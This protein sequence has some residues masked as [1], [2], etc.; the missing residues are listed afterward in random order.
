M[1]G[2]GGERDGQNGNLHL[3]TLPLLPCKSSSPCQSSHYLSTASGSIATIPVLFSCKVL[4]QHLL[5]LTNIPAKLQNSFG[6]RGFSLLWRVCEELKTRQQPLQ[7]QQQQQQ[8][9]QK[10]TMVEKNSEL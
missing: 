1:S 4:H 5:P 9:Q 3:L 7:R 8:Q 2:I 10:Q 6:G